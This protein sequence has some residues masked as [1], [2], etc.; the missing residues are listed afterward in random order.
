MLKAHF[1]HI[2]LIWMICIL[3]C[4]SANAQINATFDDSSA[5]HSAW[6]GDTS[7]FTCDNGLLQLNA[8]PSLGL[9]RIASNSSAHNQGQFYGKVSLEFNP[10]SMN[11]M[12]LDLIKGLILPI[13]S[14]LGRGG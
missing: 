4:F 5:W 2:G 14:L 3:L 1:V 7:A 13:R 8:D 6:W 9:A 12:V 10:S 11:H